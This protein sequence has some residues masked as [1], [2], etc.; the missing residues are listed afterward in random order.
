MADLVVAPLTSLS[1]REEVMDF[2]FPFYT[3]YLTALYLKPSTARQ[4]KLEVY[5]MHALFPS[6]TRHG[7]E[8]GKV[9]YNHFLERFSFY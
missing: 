8:I 3:E 9:V 1:S 2:T 7:K 6:I 4:V 5:Y